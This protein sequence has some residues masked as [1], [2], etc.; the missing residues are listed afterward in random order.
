L[1]DDTWERKKWA[2][3]IVEKLKEGPAYPQDFIDMGMPERSVH[4]VLKFLKEK[5]GMIFQKGRRG[6]YFL[7][8]YERGSPSNGSQAQIS[9]NCL[10][11]YLSW[12]W[13]FNTKGDR[14]QAIVEY[15]PPLPWQRDEAI[16]SE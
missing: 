16:K 9:I 10:N 8:G 5:V 14:E 15:R 11:D 4:E 6:E 3:E 13:K 2:I 7:R 1:Q 12:G